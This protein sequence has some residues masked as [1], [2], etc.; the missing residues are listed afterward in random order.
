[1]YGKASLSFAP[2]DDGYLFEAD[3]LRIRSHRA[4]RYDDEEIDERMCEDDD[5]DPLRLMKSARTGAT[6]RAFA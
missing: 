4:H 6:V 3:E 5:P 1:M 2:L